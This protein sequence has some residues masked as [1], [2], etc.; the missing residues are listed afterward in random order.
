MAAFHAFNRWLEDDWGYAYRERIFAAPMIPLV[1]VD[2]AVAELERVLARDARIVC[3]KGGPA[4]TRDGRPHPADARFDPF[5]ALVDEAGVTV[6]IHSGDAGYSRYIDDWEQVRA[7]S[8]HSPTRRCG[9][10]QRRPSAVRDHGR[11]GVPGRVRPVPERPGGQH[12]GRGRL[13]ARPLIKKLTKV[14][15]QSRRASPRTRWRRSADH[16][17]V[18]P[19]L[20]GRHG[21]VERADRGRP[22]AVRIGLAPCRGTGR[23]HRLRRRPPPPR[24]RRGRDPDH[25]A[26]QR[27]GPDPPGGRSA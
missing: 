8:G 27:S 17:W 9:R 10:P 14:Y 25:H 23:A 26:R 7:V 22:P 6:G 5:W 16:V 20:R 3:I 12:R 24:V 1:D 4:H 18:A 13:G 2:A 15:G 19:V 11:P 21:P